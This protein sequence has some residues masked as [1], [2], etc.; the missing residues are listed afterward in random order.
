MLNY[1]GSVEL[2]CLLSN[3][4]ALKTSNNQMDFFYKP[5]SVVLLA[6]AYKAHADGSGQDWLLHFGRG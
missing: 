2:A 3:G 1:G 6:F 4:Q 5:A